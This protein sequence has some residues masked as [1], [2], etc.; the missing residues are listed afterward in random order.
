MHDQPVISMIWTDG[1]CITSIPRT[2]DP[3][4]QEIFFH[5][6]SRACDDLSRA[7]RNVLLQSRYPFSEPDI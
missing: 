1:Q 4:S 3:F 5:S 7:G 6:G 2:P